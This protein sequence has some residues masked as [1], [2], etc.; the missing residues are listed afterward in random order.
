MLRQANADKDAIVQ[1]SRRI[2][3]G[4][5]GWLAL[6]SAAATEKSPGIGMHQAVL[7]S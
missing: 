5:L 7:T 1:E 3:H 4:D 6:R 2:R